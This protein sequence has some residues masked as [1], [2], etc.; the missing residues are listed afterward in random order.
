MPHLLRAALYDATSNINSQPGPH[1]ALRFKGELSRANSSQISTALKIVEGV[2]KNGNHITEMLSISDLIQLG[3]YTAVEYCG[4]PAMIFKMGRK[5]I[6]SE[7]EASSNSVQVQAASHENAVQVAKFDMMGLSAEEYVALMGSYTLG[8]ANDE[9][10]TKLGRW[11]MNP[12][13]FDNTYFQEVLMAGDSHYLKTEAD[14]KLMH[15][16]E[17]R[18]WVEAYAGD[19]NLFFENYASAHTKV[20][21][22]GQEDNLLSE[23]NDEDIVNG[24][25][26]ENK[27]K[28]WAEQFRA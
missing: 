13:V 21:E 19:Q 26:Q 22:M 7:H 20:S 8:F 14:M 9:N 18:Q 15:N 11:T 25:Y 12:Y 6:E 27:G 16:P 24:G 10:K 1:G 2:K 28:H 5:D 3:G 4:G 23:F 17:L